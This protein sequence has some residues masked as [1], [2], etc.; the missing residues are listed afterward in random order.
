MPARQ[1]HYPG[2]DESQGPMDHRAKVT[3]MAALL[4]RSAA[5]E[6]A[7]WGCF[8]ASGAVLAVTDDRNE[9]VAAACMLALE[10]GLVLRASFTLD[11]AHSGAALLRLQFEALLRAAWL[12]FAANP[13]QV[14]KLAAPLDLETEQAAKNLPGYK[15]MLAAVVK[16]APAP[17]SAPLAEFDQ[18]SRHAMNSFVH[19]GLHPL[20]R[21]RHG[22]PL[23]LG[24]QVIRHSNGLAHFAFRLLANLSGSQQRMHRVTG[25]YRDFGDCL[26]MAPPQNARP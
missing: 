10:H 24:L 21:T 14:A 15:D 1:D 6:T 3:P 23:D 17:L 12:M 2:L 7:A 26:P 22:F 13:G 8:P 5:F 18:Y 9:L 25:L 19:G 16:A 11:A 4:D 20:H